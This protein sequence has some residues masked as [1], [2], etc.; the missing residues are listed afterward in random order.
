[1]RVIKT[2]EAY[3]ADANYKFYLGRTAKGWCVTAYRMFGGGSSRQWRRYFYGPNAETN[4]RRM[5]QAYA[6]LEAA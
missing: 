2:S 6:P 5:Y 4:A 3:G 1:M